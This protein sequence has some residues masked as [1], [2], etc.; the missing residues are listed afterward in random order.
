MRPKGHKGLNNHLDD[1][2]PLLRGGCQ[3]WS[4]WSCC[5]ELSRL[6]LT[7]RLCLLLLAVRRGGFENGLAEG[8]R[9]E[10]SSR[11]TKSRPDQRIESNLRISDLLGNRNSMLERYP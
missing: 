5:G 11:F 8:V 6:A 3:G 7:A 4:D 1:T 2:A 9:F 10:F